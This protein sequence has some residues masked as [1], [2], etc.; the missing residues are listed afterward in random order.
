MKRAFAAIFL[1]STISLARP[2]E[3]QPLP[4]WAE[5]VAESHCGYLKMGIDWGDAM[6]QAFRDQR[7]W[8]DDMIAAGEISNKIILAA[9]MR[10]CDSLNRSAFEKHSRPSATPS[11]S[12]NFQL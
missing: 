5:L 3:A 7:L 12:K 9:I 1:F 2:S 10:R 6:S 11:K 8:V 4:V